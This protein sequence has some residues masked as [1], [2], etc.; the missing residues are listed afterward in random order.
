[1]RGDMRRASLSRRRLN[2]GDGTG[3]LLE[4]EKPVR[5]RSQERSV[6]DVRG[7]IKVLDDDHHS[8]ASSTA[9]SEEM[10]EELDPL[11]PSP[12]SVTLC[13]GNVNGHNNKV[14]LSPKSKTREVPKI[15][16]YH[17]RSVSDPFDVPGLEQPESGDSSTATPVNALPTLPRYPV[18]ETRDLNCWS[19]PPVEIFKVRGK[20]YLKDKKKVPSAPYLFSARGC[21]LLLFPEG[22]EDNV[23]M[24]ER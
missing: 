22:Q 2:S 3:I 18:A 17:R 4:G 8:R 14:T 1:M 11:D 21:D 9:G 23:S 6:S 13:V 12:K 16:K 10:L 24:M 20:N 7:S 5:S 15:N 19:E